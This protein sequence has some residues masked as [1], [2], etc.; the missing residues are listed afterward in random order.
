MTRSAQAV[1]AAALPP[2]IAALH[3][4]WQGGGA[5]II[6][7]KARRWLDSHQAGPRASP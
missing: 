4:G 1:P 5:D 7:G 3:P 2:G 6:S